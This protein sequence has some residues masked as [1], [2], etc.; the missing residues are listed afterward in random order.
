MRKY[1]SAGD[2]Y[3]HYQDVSLP[4]TIKAIL[5]LP[6]MTFLAHHLRRFSCFHPSLVDRD[7]R[8]RQEQLTYIAQLGSTT[9]FKLDADAAP[10][11]EF[12][13]VAV[14]YL[15]WVS[16]GTSA[17]LMLILEQAAGSDEWCV[18]WKECFDEDFPQNCRSDGVLEG[19]LRKRSPLP[20]PSSQTTS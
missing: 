4:F 10:Q 1:C 2:H 8:T 3:Y 5:I 6:A 17:R 16:H 14:H 12:T 9:T 15:G 20:G 19:K 13:R 11:S 7:P 18:R